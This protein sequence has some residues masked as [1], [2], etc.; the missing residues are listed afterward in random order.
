M[1]IL[2]IS[3]SGLNAALAGIRT[4]QHNIANA[5]TD[6][7]HRQ[8]VNQTTHLPQSLGGL[9]YGNGVQVA[10]VARQYSSFLDNQ[11]R[12][13]QGLQS[14]SEIYS[15]YSAQVDD[16]LGGKSGLN[17]AM[18]TFFDGVNEVANDPTSSVARQQMLSSGQNLASRMSF[19]GSQL[20]GIKTSINNQ[21]G[22]MATEINGYLGK[23][24]TLN[25]SI[26]TGRSGQEAS[27]DLLDQRE[28]LVNELNKL[29][30]VTQ[31]QQ[32]DGSVNIVLTS[33]Q[34][35]V[36]GSNAVTVKSVDDAADPSLKTLGIEQ[37][38]NT[39]RVNESQLSG[40]ELGGLLAFRREV[41]L[42]SMN[43]LGRVAIALADQFNSIHASGYDLD[44][45]TGQNFFSDAASLLR[46]PVAN[47]DN[48][49]TGTLAAALTDSNALTGSDYRLNYDGTN[50]TL[51]RLSDG[52][53]STAASLAAVTSIGGQDQGFSLTGGGAPAAG[54]SWRISLTGDGALTFGVEV[55][56]P[57]Q[58][59][60]AGPVATAATAGNAGTAYI[61]SGSVSLATSLSGGV[62]LPSSITLTYSSATNQISVSG[63]VP[64]VA[65]VTYSSGSAIN[66][67]GI[68][69]TIR[70][71]PSD[72]DTF[73]ISNGAGGT[74]DAR[75]ALLLAS[76]QTHTGMSGST[77]SYSGVYTQL[78]GRNAT[79]AQGSDTNLAAYTTMTTQAKETQQSLSGVNLDEEAV[80][81]VEYQQAYQAAS[82]AI[83]VAST[84]FDEILNVVR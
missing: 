47:A 10:A 48:T 45:N 30:S 61:D 68:T 54:D 58:I 65:A 21:V 79:L 20:N 70:G 60:A 75:N 7:Y 42:P 26:A 15:A 25:G 46:Q 50:Y 4:T 14:Y 34:A 29:V 78:V 33:G 28:Q 59:A 43:D 52:A 37:N 3:V 71:T 40:G 5:G 55:T 36:V 80:K 19:L 66:I 74:G 8:T 31:I 62:P 32:S 1:G 12:T 27:N 82:K 6:G 22:S 44:G 51:T 38:G 23:I 16:L 49:G 24:A 11:V 9:Y 53:S 57:A 17:N 41:L 84:L 81:L 64:P 67:N 2:G 18:Q 76:L 35:L 77:A 83:Q 73:T 39:Q 13:Y 63:A 56:D 72:G 69:V